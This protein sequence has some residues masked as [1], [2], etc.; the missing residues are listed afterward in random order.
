MK[1]RSLRDITVFFLLGALTL[2]LGAEPSFGA[3]PFASPLIDTATLAE[4]L[5]KAGPVLIDAEAKELYERAHLPGAVNLPYLDLEDA[6]EN[7]ATGRPIFPQRGAGKFA[8][9]GITR[10]TEVVVYD[11]GNG[12][13][14]SAV[15]YVL[16]YLGHDKVK[17]LDGGFR[18]WLKEGRLLTQEAP[19]VTKAVYK[20]KPNEEFVLTTGQVAKGQARVVDARSLGEYSGKEMGGARRGGH[21]P[22]AVSLPW[23]RVV[24]KLSTFQSPARMQAVFKQAGL[25]P[26]QEIITYCNPG[27]GRSTF[28]YLALQ[29]AGYE[30]V[31]V[32]PGSWIEWAADPARPIER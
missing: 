26:G 11:G 6:E 25:D 7:A 1:R 2:L 21:I 12:R 3:S 22:G 31:T 9:L 32:Y 17:I 13:A 5:G 16:R 20:P 14:A 10:D 27:I 4:R 18:K 30:R 23:D 8:A 19:R 29:L 28:L 15:W 24:G